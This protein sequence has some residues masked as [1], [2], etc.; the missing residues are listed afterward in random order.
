MPENFVRSKH[1]SVYT[2][3]TSRE[4]LN[5]LLFI[6]RKQA[7]FKCDVLED[8]VREYYKKHFDDD[9]IYGT[10]TRRAKEV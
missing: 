10:G 2:F 7:R 4:T 6:S 8:A 9:Y 5:L 3:R 1:P